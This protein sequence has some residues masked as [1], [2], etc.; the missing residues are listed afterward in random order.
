LPRIEHT[1]VREHGPPRV[2]LVLVLVVVVAAAAAATAAAARRVP[3]CTALRAASPRLRRRGRRLCAHPRPMRGPRPVGPCRLRPKRAFR[4]RRRR[5]RARRRDR[6]TELRLQ[7][8]SVHLRLRCR[9][10]RLR[11]PRLP[12]KPPFEPLKPFEPLESLKAPRLKRPQQQRLPRGLFSARSPGA[13]LP[14]SA[15]GQA[16]RLRC[17]ERS[18]ARVSSASARACASEKSL[19]CPLQ[20]AVTGGRDASPLR[21]R[22]PPLLLPLPMSLLYTPLSTEV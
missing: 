18:A 12:P 14:L 11:R 1:R 21:A 2:A 4:R 7:P 22:N 10:L 15:G 5:C 13:R 8:R 20:P 19:A 6:H 3:I 17:S 16:C 9:R